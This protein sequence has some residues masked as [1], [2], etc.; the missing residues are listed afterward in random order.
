MIHCVRLFVALGGADSSDY[1]SDGASTRMTSTDRDNTAETVVDY[2]S[3]YTD[4]ADDGDARYHNR[5]A[6]PNDMTSEQMFDGP[7]TSADDGT[8]STSEQTADDDVSEGTSS[9]GR[10]NTARRGSRNVARRGRG[11]ARGRGGGPF[12]DRKARHV[13]R[14]RTKQR[15]NV[16]WFGTFVLLL[17][18]ELIRL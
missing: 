6:L 9:R 8:V 18:F 16:S 17:Q 11:G 2:T 5:Y 12:V 10:G 1:R 14:Q 15:S 3:I 4:I 13:L 7:S